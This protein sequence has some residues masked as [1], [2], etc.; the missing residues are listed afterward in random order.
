M[1]VRV[2]VP[3]DENGKYWYD[4]DAA[5]AAVAFFSNYL[6]HFKGEWA[7]QPFVLSEWQANIIRNIFGWKGQDG[8]RRYRTVYVWVPRKNG[9]TT[10][11]GGIALLLLM[12]DAEPSPEVYCIART[13]D[14]ANIVFSFVTQMIANSAELSAVLTPW[15][16]SIWCDKLSGVIVPLSGKPAGKHGLNA[17]AVIGDELHEWADDDLYTFIHQSEGTRRQ[18]MDFLISTAGKRDGVGWEHWQLCESILEGEIDAPDTF[19]FIA[20][21]DPE[22]EKED[23]NYWTYPETMRDA[24]PGYGVSVKPSTMSSEVEK[25]KK[26]PR[27]ENDVKRYYLNLWVDQAVR[28][29]NMTAWDACGHKQKENAP[30]PG[31]CVRDPKRLPTIYARSNVNWRWSHFPEELKGRRCLVGVD[32]SSTTDLTCIILVFPPEEDGEAW[33]VMC[34][35]Y[36]PEDDLEEKTKRDHFDYQAAADIGALILTP[37]NVVDYDLIYDDI[38]KA[39]E[40]YQIETVGIDRWNATG[41]AVKLEAAGLTVT[42]FGQGFGSMSGPSKY[43]ERIVLQKRLD[44]GGH[45]VLRSN[46]RHVAITKDAADNIKPVKDKS[47]GRI[48]GIV[49]TIIGIGVSDDYLTDSTASVYD[50]RGVLTGEQD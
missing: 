6:K 27:R 2:T 32:L 16:T 19:V 39:G 33:K 38:V 35:F 13:K 24:N 30:G 40:D 42:L 22:Q 15:K 48:D 41:I 31:P 9:K 34:R 21:A 23:P 12:G 18:P 45:P 47:T 1:S 10:L 43:L 8:L 17:N 11:A 44:H 46:A 20:A 36:L 4:E 26:N 49:G 7:G 50:K 29:L 28:W 3:T 14:Q 5:E 37:G 25:A